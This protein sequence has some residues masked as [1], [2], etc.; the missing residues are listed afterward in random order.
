VGD[1]AVTDALDA[2]AGAGSAGRRHQVA[3]LG[4]VTP[5]D[6]ER[7]APLGVIANVSPL[8]ARLDPVLVQTKLPLLTAAQRQRHFPF[9]SLE[10]VGVPIAFGL[11]GR[12]RHPTRSLHCTQP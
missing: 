2:V 11:T 3:H 10:R 12:S 6:L 4:L 8:W 1:R 7:M 5:D 9:G